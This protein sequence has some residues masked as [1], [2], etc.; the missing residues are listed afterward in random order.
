M[1]QIREELIG[2]TGVSG[3]VGAKVASLL[4]AQGHRLRLVAR[5]P[6]KAPSLPGAEVVPFSASYD[7][8]EALHT[9]FDGVH[10]LFLVSAHEAHDRVALHHNA[11]RAAVEAKV[12]RIVYL[13]FLAA[14]P[15]ATFTYAR[16][17]YYTEEMIYSSGLAYTFLR[18]SLY[19]D[20]VPHLCRDDGTIA[21]PAGDGY[22]AWVAR[23]DV[24]PA[25]AG[26]LGEGDEHDGRTYDLTGSQT[27]TMAET[28]AVLAKAVSRPIT[29]QDESLDEAWASRA[30][31]GAPHWEIEGWITSYAAIATGEMDVVSA[32]VGDLTGR[33]PIPLLD[34]LRGNP[35]ALRRLTRV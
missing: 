15:D 25:A 2:V 33:D 12:E 14:A 13:S 8:P 9:A 1:A 19:A 21:G 7:D 11:V 3:A 5:T 35:E 10:T 6:A 22:I 18:S 32:A 30:S 20:I 24:A 28:A 34:V 16:D 17:H 27:L 23:D 31:S 29:Y 4:A 26:V